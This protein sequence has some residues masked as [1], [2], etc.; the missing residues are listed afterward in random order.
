MTV[1]SWPKHVLVLNE[2]KGFALGLGE[3]FAEGFRGHGCQVDVL[4]RD[5]TW[6]KDYDL[7]LGF[8]PHDWETSL[9]PA[10]ERLLAYPQ[11]RRPFFFWWFTE[12]TPD[13]RWPIPLV[14][15]LAKWHGAGNLCIRQLPHVRSYRWV[16]WWE[17]SFLRRHFR[18]MVIG[19]AFAFQYRGLINAMAVTATSRAKYLERHGFT[20]IA[21]PIGYHPLLHGRDLGLQRDI[22]VGFL[23]R[24]HTSRRIKLV[25]KIRQELER[26]NIQMVIHT[27]GLEGDERT[28]FLNRTKILLNIFQAY[29][30]FIG[31]RFLFAAANKTLLVS[32]PMI[33]TDTIIPGRHVVTT[34][35]GTL[36]E[37]I[38]HYLTHD[39]ERDN[40]VRQ[41]NH[42]I[43]NELSIHNIVGR[44]L[45]H[46]RNLHF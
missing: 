28:R 23:G 7:V 31:L 46:A 16:R 36:V 4:Q 29:H 40:I 3:I 38:I 43:Q 45:N 44:I 17:T 13:P 21:V 39:K 20:P 11:E 9:L 35:V 19:E 27:E 2:R 42:L 15:S 32:E 8:G 10:I 18:L 41:A 33:D 22:P 26:H 25:E 30:G 14:R 34:P 6:D 5:L 24:M 1:S 37:K 12:A